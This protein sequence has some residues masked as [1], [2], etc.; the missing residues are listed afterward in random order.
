MFIV[1]GILR[2]TCTYIE[3]GPAMVEHIILRANL[4]PSMKVASEFDC[5]DGKHYIIVKWDISLMHSIDSP[6]LQA[7]MDALKEGDEMIESTKNNVPKV[8]LPLDN[9]AIS[10][11]Y[12]LSF[13]GYIILSEKTKT[14]EDGKQET[15][16]M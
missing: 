7:L 11:K 1:D 3:Y 12:W 6:A 4:D 2:G 5:S 10:M 13:Q 15:I 8:S 14:G 9:D 16:D